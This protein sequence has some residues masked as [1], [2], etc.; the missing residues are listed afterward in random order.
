MRSIAAAGAAALVTASCVLL[1]ACSTGGVLPEASDRPTATPTAEPWDPGAV[2]DP[3]GAIEV[4]PAQRGDCP[5]DPA[6]TDLITFVVASGDDTRPVRV[7][8]PVSRADGTLFVRRMTQPGPV[9][10]AVLAECSDAGPARRSYRAT[11]EFGPLSCAR[12]V[13]GR[14]VASDEDAGD[15]DGARVDCTGD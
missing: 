11:A 12:F 2:P 13:G 10:T 4:L 3:G 7:T 1:S 9:L 5:V 6:A 14:L 8:Y 15:A